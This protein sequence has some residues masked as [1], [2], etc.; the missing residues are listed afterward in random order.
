MKTTDGKI[1]NDDS[2]LFKKMY[3]CR[4]TQNHVHLLTNGK[5]RDI[6]EL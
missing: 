3:F 2:G 5:Y 1:K 4:V 6:F